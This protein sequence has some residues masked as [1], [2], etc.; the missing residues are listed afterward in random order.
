MS[1]MVDINPFIFQTSKVCHYLSSVVLLKFCDA[2]VRN[3][4][5]GLEHYS[6]QCQPAATPA[7]RVC[8]PWWHERH[9]RGRGEP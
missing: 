9:E 3:E 5:F 2:V 6:F 4:D 8:Q 7:T 1:S